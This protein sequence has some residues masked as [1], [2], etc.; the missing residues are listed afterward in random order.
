MMKKGGHLNMTTNLIYAYKKKSSNKIV[1]VGQTCDLNYRNKQHI[2]YDPF[3]INNPEYEYPLSRGIR[4]YGEDEY[5]L[6]ILEDNL[7][8]E[9]LNEREKY[10]IS[11]YDTYFNGY[12]Q[13]IGGSNPTQPIFDEKSIDRVIEMLQDES[14]SY[15][16]IIEKTGISMTHIYNINTG[17]RRRRDNL[18]Y[19][20]RK[21]NIKGTK[22]LKFSPEECQ[23]IHEEILKNDKTIVQIAEEFNCSK[24]VISDINNGKTKAYKL[25]GYIYP[26]R[27]SHQV[28]KKIYW[29]NK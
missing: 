24:R 25:E 29:E 5:E 22:G 11:F 4:K 17:Q 7:Q 13:T 21:S 8:K 19:P 18:E 20:I 3:N 6:I 15:K 14:Y 10:W 12:N 9:Q 23:K 2:K 26:L 27:N 28:S 1:Y 16:D